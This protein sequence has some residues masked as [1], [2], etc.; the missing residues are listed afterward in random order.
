MSQKNFTEMTRE[1][2][3]HSL[4]SLAASGKVS[5]DFFAEIIYTAVSRFALPMHELRSF[6]GLSPLAIDHWIQKKNLPQQIVRP[7][8]LL[9]IVD[10][11]A[12]LS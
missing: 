6:F 1:E 11:L 10:K 5:D 2:F 12:I 4:Q 7:K 3:I 8:M 9:W